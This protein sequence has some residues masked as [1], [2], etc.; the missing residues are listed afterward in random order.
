[1]AS[2][3]ACRHISQAYQGKPAHA[4]CRLPRRACWFT[5][6]IGARLPDRA[7]APPRL[8]GGQVV[9]FN[10]SKTQL[11]NQMESVSLELS[12]LSHSRCPRPE[13]LIF[14]VKVGIRGHTNLAN[15][16][17]RTD[18]RGA[19]FRLSRSAAVNAA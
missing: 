1:M 18:R 15:V 10:Y 13:H 12:V 9:V 8:R 2:D 6:G 4:E 19:A 5:A 17:T 16:F 14:L 3:D 7:A 11:P